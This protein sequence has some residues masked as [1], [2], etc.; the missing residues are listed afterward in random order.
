ML[1]YYTAE[2]I[3]AAEAPLLAALPDGVLMRRAATGLAGAVG[4]ELRRRTGGVS[5]RSVCAV[6]GS[7]NNGGDALWAGTLLRRRGAAASAILLSP[8]R[9]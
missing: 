5:G 4:V 6:V 2:V 7:G 1:S 9:T 3:R 8:E